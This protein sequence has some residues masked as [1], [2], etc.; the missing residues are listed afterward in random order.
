LI[1]IP[2]GQS[3]WDEQHRLIGSAEIPLSDEGRKQ[4]IHWGDQI[5]SA[6]GM[7]IIYSSTGGPSEETARLIAGQFKIRH[8]KEADLSEMNLGLWQGLTLEEVKLRHPKAYREWQ[9]SPGNITPPEGETMNEAQLRMD[10]TISKL[11]KKHEGMVVG[12]VLGKIGLSL[13]RLLRE[14]RDM[15]AFGEMN[16]GPLTWHEY[17]IQNLSVAG[18]E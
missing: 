7:N 13:E 14:Q 5:R 1:L 15:N 12:V 18:K 11:I 2:S 10:Y 9:E 17:A 8:R 4:A 3:V 16:Q 6:V